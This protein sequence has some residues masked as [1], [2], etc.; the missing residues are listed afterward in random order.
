MLPD[1]YDFSNHSL[2]EIPSISKPNL[3][4]RLSLASNFLRAIPNMADFSMLR[5]LDISHNQLVDL[6]HISAI[7]PLRELDCS[8]NRIVSLA[9]V[10]PLTNLEILRASHNRIAT[11]V[12]QMPE[13]LIDCDLSSNELSSF[14]FLQRKFPFS[15]ER[16]DISS[17]LVGDVIELRYLSVFNNLTCLNTGILASHPNL[18]VLRLVKHICPTLTLFDGADCTDVVT[19]AVQFPAD[20]ELYEVLVHGTEDELCHLI[21]YPDLTVKWTEPSFIEYEEDLEAKEL[22]DLERRIGQI[23]QRLPRIPEPQAPP[24][25]NGKADEI[26]AMRREIQDL[27]DQLGKL[28]DLLYVQDRAVREIF[29]GKTDENL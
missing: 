29:D 7:K 3:V 19:D 20:E 22:E 28:L 25:Y 9:F 12:A 11:V 17:N 4:I 6:T 26:K 23:E 27:R 10:G 21:E 8:H 15:L 14:E 5:S 18:Q 13:P 24:V 2:F 1:S 16:L